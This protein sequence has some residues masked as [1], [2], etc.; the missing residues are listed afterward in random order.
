MNE[1]PEHFCSEWS[2][3]VPTETGLYWV[4]GPEHYLDGE[5]ITRL[6]YFLPRS[7]GKMHGRSIA[8]DPGG[9]IAL[10]HWWWDGVKDEQGSKGPLPLRFAPACIAPPVS[11]VEEG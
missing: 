2:N 6:A 10:E 1:N 3:D 7:D 8:P 4:W 5:S 11:D 9:A